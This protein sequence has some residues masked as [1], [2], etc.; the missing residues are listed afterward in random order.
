MGTDASWRRRRRDGAG[1]HGHA[2]PLC[3]SNATPSINR[4]RW[5]H[6]RTSR[7]VYSTLLRVWTA[8]TPS[9]GLP[10][11]WSIGKPIGLSS[12]R[13]EPRRDRFRR[14]RGRGRPTTGGETT[15][16]AGAT[17]ACATAGSTKQASGEEEYELLV[18]GEGVSH[19]SSP[20]SPGTDYSGEGPIGTGSTGSRAHDLLV[21]QG[22]CCGV[23]ARVLI[24][25]GAT[26]D[27]VA[28]RFAKTLR[29]QELVPVGDLRVVRVA[30]GTVHRV[31]RELPATL[32]FGSGCVIMR[33]LLEV[34][35]E[36]YDII[37]GKPWLTENNPVIDWV[38]NS[39]TFAVPGPAID[40]CAKEA[41]PRRRAIVTLKGCSAPPRVR[42]LKR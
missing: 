4:S 38:N 23:P 17:T 12:E 37:L 7:F 18:P 32:D 39:V 21:V 2:P 11:S 28:C 26:D 22:V 29:D 14:P 40:S 35:L 33:P 9:T 42:V 20:G 30:D 16:G 3:K 6:C 19:P 34:D 25:S 10:W 13:A 31:E 36:G 15:A 5:R 41:G 24:D 8:R 1:R 27:F